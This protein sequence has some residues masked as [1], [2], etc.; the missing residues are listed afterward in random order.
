[1]MSLRGTLWWDGAGYAKTSCDSNFLAL[2]LMTPWATRWIRSAA[3]LHTQ[4]SCR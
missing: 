4:L 1:M 3:R 2:A